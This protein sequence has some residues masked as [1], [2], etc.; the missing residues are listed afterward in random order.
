MRSE[1]AAGVAGGKVEHGGVRS[2]EYKE[3]TSGSSDLFML[4]RDNTE[5]I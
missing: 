5:G 4:E 1:R 3:G 2:R